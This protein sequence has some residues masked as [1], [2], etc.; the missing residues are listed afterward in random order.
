MAP[1]TASST[2]ALF[3]RPRSCSMIMLRESADRRS[4]SS[5]TTWWNNGDLPS[6]GRLRQGTSA[7]PKESSTRHPKRLSRT[8]PN[9]AKNCANS[10]ADGWKRPLSREISM[11]PT[12]SSTA[13]RRRLALTSFPNTVSESGIWSSRQPSPS[14]PQLSV[15]RSRPQILPKPAKY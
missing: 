2:N 10:G 12:D 8:C 9:C 15:R 6:R 5:L 3:G 14:W 1:L 4:E 11:R 7:R 13:R